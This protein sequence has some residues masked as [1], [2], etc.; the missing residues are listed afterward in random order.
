MLISTGDIN[1]VSWGCEIS[2]V[3]QSMYLLLS[4][5]CV[6]SCKAGTWPDS[7][8]ARPSGPQWGGVPASVQSPLFSLHLS[9]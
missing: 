5:T 1:K 9:G 2:K 8:T 4:P 6:T 3:P 7:G